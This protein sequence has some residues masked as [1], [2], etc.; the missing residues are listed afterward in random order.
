VNG[1]FWISL[2]RSVGTGR[3]KSKGL[4]YEIW[5]KSTKLLTAPANVTTMLRYWVYSFWVRFETS[6]AV[7]IFGD[8]RNEE[9]QIFKLVMSVRLYVQNNSI[10]TERQ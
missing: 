5:S 8:I 1:K 6:A 10:T 3:R 2:V 4:Q 7:P 9:E